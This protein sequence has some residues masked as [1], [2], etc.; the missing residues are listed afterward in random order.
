M[1]REEIKSWFSLV[2]LP[3]QLFSSLC[4]S[5][6][7]FCEM[8]LLFVCFSVFGSFPEIEIASSVYGLRVAESSWFQRLDT[9]LDKSEVCRC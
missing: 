6:F 9:V 8:L 1:V 4:I 7:G 3:K 2:F 5:A